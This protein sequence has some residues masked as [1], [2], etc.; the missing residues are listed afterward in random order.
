MEIKVFSNPE[1]NAHDNW[2]ILNT[3]INKLAAAESRGDL[4]SVMYPTNLSRKTQGK[5]EE[6]KK[7]ETEKISEKNEATE[8][9]EI[10]VAAAKP[11]EQTTS[12]EKTNFVMKHKFGMKM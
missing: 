8:K 5:T 10:T 9:K 1:T 4:D 7:T 6:L 11:V 3:A 12:P 2:D